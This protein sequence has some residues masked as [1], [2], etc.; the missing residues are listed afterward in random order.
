MKH[1][2]PL[3]LLAVLLLAGCQTGDTSARRD[4]SNPSFD[5]FQPKIVERAK[6]LRDLDPTLTQEQ[7]MAR[8]SQDFTAARSRE[9]KKQSDSQQ[10]KNF[11]EALAQSTKN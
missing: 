10:Q 3:I 2:L 4:Y 7:A 9:K 1:Q 11:E 8:A 6:L 5:T